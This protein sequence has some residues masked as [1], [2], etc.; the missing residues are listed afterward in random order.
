VANIVAVSTG[1][2][3]GNLFH[4]WDGMDEIDAAASVQQYAALLDERLCA[5]YPGAEITVDWQDAEGTL[6]FPLK[7]RVW[8]DD[9]T[10]ADSAIDLHHDAEDVD[11]LARQV[12]EDYDAWVIGIGQG[13]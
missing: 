7:T 3:T 6:P 10:D 13:A 4:G 9:G 8:Y 5:A 1:F 12:Y 11:E 2:L